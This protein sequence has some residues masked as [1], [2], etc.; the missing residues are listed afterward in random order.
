[1]PS[2]SSKDLILGINETPP[3][4]REEFQEIVNKVRDME[5]GEGQ[6][7]D[8]PNGIIIEEVNRLQQSLMNTRTKGN[9]GFVECDFDRPWFSQLYVFIA[10]PDEK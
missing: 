3:K 9:P 2:I 4:F 1:M 10:M 8:L 5:I 6:T 7:F